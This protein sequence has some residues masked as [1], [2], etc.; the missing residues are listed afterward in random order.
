MFQLVGNDEDFLYDILIEE[1]VQ[2]HIWS[3]RD[4]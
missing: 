4:S 1:Q 2:V 3:Q